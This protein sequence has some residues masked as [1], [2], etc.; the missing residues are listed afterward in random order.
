MHSENALYRNLD[1]E[2]RARLDAIMDRRRRCAREDVISFDELYAEGDDKRQWRALL[3]FEQQILP[4]GDHYAYK[5][6]KLP[7]DCFEPEVFLYKH[8]IDKLKTFKNIGD[9]AILD[10]G[11]FAGDTVLTLRE[12]VDN[13]I[14]SFEPDPTNYAHALRTL[15]L[16]KELLSRGG[17]M[18]LENIALGDVEGKNKI[19]TPL[20]NG[21][22]IGAASMLVGEHADAGT[23]VSVRTLDSYVAEHN[24]NVGM[25]KVDIEGYEQRFLAGALE[26]IKAQKPIL[27]ISIYHNRNDFYNIKPMIENLG[28]GYKFDFFQGVS[29]WVVNDIMLACEVR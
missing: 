4:C 21:N 2:A 14:Y 17:K 12:L 10:V 1:D 3:E 19:I 15:E 7:I 24:I 27:L 20:Y 26:T 5:H 9:R 6:Y 16:N 11:C 28:L 22:Y 25:I 13:D 18:V 8:G 23:E 29:R